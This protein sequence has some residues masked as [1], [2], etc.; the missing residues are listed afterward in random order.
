MVSANRTEHDKI[1]EGQSNGL[2]YNLSWQKRILRWFP[3]DRPNDDLGS[4]HFTAKSSWSKTGRTPGVPSVRISHVDSAAR[5]RSG[6]AD[7]RYAQRRGG[8][9]GGIGLNADNVGMTATETIP[10]TRAF[11]AHLL[12]TSARGGISRRCLA[13][14]VRRTS[15]LV[16]PYIC[17]AR[18][19]VERLGR[20]L[21]T[22][23][24]M[25]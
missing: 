3:D 14:S 5:R 2:Y 24:P 4:G 19:G 8:H 25:R 12:G 15:H 21:E 11:W 16:L 20:L 10:P 13:A 6:H 22:Y 1:S 23:A 17:S 9:L 18:Q 7:D